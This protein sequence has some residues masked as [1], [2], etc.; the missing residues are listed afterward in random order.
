MPDSGL[1]PNDIRFQYDVIKGQSESI[2]VMTGALMEQQKTLG[3]IVERLVRI[4][5]NKVDS[6][7]TVIES[8]IEAL[9]AERNQRAGMAKVIE[10]IFKS[11]L[12]GWLVGAAGLV[13][14]MV[15][16]GKGQ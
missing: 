2:R 13:W 8:E 4:E 1:D 14:F 12:I 5:S 6:R 16:G 15:T 11:P 3:E 7:V 9:K 10:I